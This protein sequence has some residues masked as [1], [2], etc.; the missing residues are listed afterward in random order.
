[1][2]FISP[3][4]FCKLLWVRYSKNDS[5]LLSFDDGFHSNRLIVDNIL[6][7]LGIKALFFIISN[8]AELGPKDNWRRFV[9]NNICP[10]IRE[11]M[12]VQICLIWIGMI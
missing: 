6:N 11:K 10:E 7:E 12:F 1:M 9:A 2:G 5:L 4:K 3:D 8:F